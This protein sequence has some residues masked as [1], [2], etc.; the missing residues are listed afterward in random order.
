VTTLSPLSSASYSSAPL[1]NAALPAVSSTKVA[2]QGSASPQQSTIVAIGAANQASSPQTY[3]LQSGPAAAIPAVWETQSDDA[4]SSLMANNFSSQSPAGRFNGLGSALLNFFKSGGTNFSQSVMQA[5]AGGQGNPS[6]QAGNQLTIKTKSGVEVDISLDSE[7]NGLAVKVTSSG[8]LSDAER[9][10]IEK[11][12]GAFQDAIDGLDASQPHLDLSGLTQFDSS[13]LSSVD[14][15]SDVMS[16]ASPVPQS[17]DFHSDSLLRTVSL[18]GA[19]GTVK[20]NV[21]MSDAASWGTQKQR[22]DAINSYLKQFD[23][24]TSR[25]KGDASLMGMFKDAFTQMN[26]DYG[27]PS[28][29]SSA[30]PL[31]EVDHAMLTGLADFNASVTQSPKASNPAQLNELDTFSYQVSQ[32][33]NINGA[34]ALERS[35]SQQQ[36]SHLTAS[37]HTSLIPDV[38]LKLSTLKDSQN[39]YYQ[40][41]DDKAS[42]AISIGYHKGKLFKASLN[43]S[44]NQSTHL[45]KYEMGSVTEDTTTPFNASQTRDILATL[46]PFMQNGKPKPD[47]DPYQWQQTLSNV[48][49]LV[50]LQGDPADLRSGGA[51]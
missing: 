49:D 45:L 29:Q 35:I 44:A 14:L 20:V 10:A 16:G 22:T 42:S 6:L 25:G 23:Q 43:Q 26:S 24:A 11:L 39:Y 17:L 41:I 15:H 32:D 46:Q 4:V 27:V 31:N 2:A 47:L 8:D 5:P 7:E 30:T 19:A 21:D 51:G 40:Q 1:Q 9:G 3:S 34:S 12:S 36:Q 48:H 13:L 18:T 50:S 38:P 28:P 37:Y 33:T